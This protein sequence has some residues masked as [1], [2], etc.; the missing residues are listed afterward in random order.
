M[1]SAVRFCSGAFKQCGQFWY[2]WFAGRPDWVGLRGC[3]GG[4][5]GTLLGDAAPFPLFLAVGWCWFFLAPRCVDLRSTSALEGFLATGIRA[6]TVASLTPPA[7]RFPP[8]PTGHWGFFAGYLC[9]C[10]NQGCSEGTHC[11]PALLCLDVQQKLVL[12]PTC[13]Y[14][15]YS[16]VLSCLSVRVCT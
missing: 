15:S 12:P 4:L 5:C 1:G 2:G 9:S 10:F 14:H 11:A 3:F 6:I 13:F 8:A 16:Y 7:T